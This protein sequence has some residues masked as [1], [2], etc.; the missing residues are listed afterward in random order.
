MSLYKIFASPLKFGHQEEGLFRLLWTA[1][2][3]YRHQLEERS[4]ICVLRDAFNNKFTNPDQAVKC[5][6]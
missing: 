4:L 6:G 1:A 5:L 2:S 3:R